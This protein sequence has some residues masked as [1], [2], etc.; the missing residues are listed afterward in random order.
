M[1]SAT[2]RTPSWVS[3]M[4]AG[5]RKNGGRVLATKRPEEF[6]TIYTRADGY[7]LNGECVRY[8]IAEGFLVPEDGGLLGDDPTYYRVAD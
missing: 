8:C 5:I 4:L 2:T 3:G 1:I 7:P 6:L